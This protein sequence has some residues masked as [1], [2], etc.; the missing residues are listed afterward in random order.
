MDNL[1]IQLPF[2]GISNMEFLHELPIAETEWKDRYFSSDF[3]DCIN[4]CVCDG[5]KL[6]SFDYY[7][8]HKFKN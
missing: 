7:S 4:K 8:E 1:L 3:A 5:D 2:F 6:I